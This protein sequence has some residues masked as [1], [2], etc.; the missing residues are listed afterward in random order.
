MPMSPTSVT[1]GKCPLSPDG[2]LTSDNNAKNKA[3]RKL[4]T[5][6][7]ERQLV[8]VSTGLKKF[9]PKIPKLI[10]L[11][12]LTFI[13]S[14]PYHV[15]FDKNLKIKHGGVKLQEIC[16]GINTEGARVDDFLFF[17]HPQ[18]SLNVP[19]IQ[20]FINNI[21]MAEIKKEVMSEHYRGKPS[22]SVRGTIQ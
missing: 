13:T 3:F 20:V 19:S 11:D 4:R 17:R 2:N 6:V 7:K 14:F 18:I 1:S 22:L 16:P 9:E 8:P 12:G 10:L 5:A 15:I 21:F